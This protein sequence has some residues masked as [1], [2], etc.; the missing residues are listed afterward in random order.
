[1]LDL[2]IVATGLEL[3]GHTLHMLME[4]NPG[5]TLVTDRPTLDSASASE[6]CMMT[7]Q[8]CSMAN[9]YVPHE[10]NNTI[11][12]RCWTRIP[13]AAIYCSFS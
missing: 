13:A 1:M 3:L 2:I 7:L 9:V 10:A 8:S 6:G 11:A 4:Y 12:H 5:S